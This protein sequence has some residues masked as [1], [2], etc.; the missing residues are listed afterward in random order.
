MNSVRHVSMIEWPVRDDC[1]VIA[2]MP[3]TALAKSIGRTPFY[4]YDRRLIDER[5]ALLRRHLPPSVKLHYAIKA[6]PMPE[7]VRH[8]VGLVDGLDVASSGELAIALE[9]GMH[10]NDISFAGPGKSETELDFGGSQNLRADAICETSRREYR[11]RFRHSV[12]SGRSAAGS[13][14]DRYEPANAYRSPR[15]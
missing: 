2:G 5:V 3:L 11:R 1:L 15:Y 13:R 10:T 8:M 12:F 14:A 6:N 7:L 4:A 9:S